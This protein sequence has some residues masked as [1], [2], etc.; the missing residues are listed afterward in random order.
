MGRM[1]KEN[2]TQKHICYS[3]SSIAG[4]EAKIDIIKLISPSSHTVSLSSLPVFQLEEE[5]LDCMMVT[6][7]FILKKLEA[8]V[9]LTLFQFLWTRRL[10]KK[11]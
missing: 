8:L 10:E 6:Q 11:F 1:A 5:V 7:T 3:L 2:N 9:A 4:D